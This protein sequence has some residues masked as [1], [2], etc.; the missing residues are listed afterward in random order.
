MNTLKKLIHSPQV[1]RFV[2]PVVLGILF[3]ISRKIAISL[4]HAQPFSVEILNP[5]MFLC[6]TLLCIFSYITL[7]LYPSFWITDR[8]SKKSNRLLLMPCLLIPVFFTLI[9]HIV[10]LNEPLHHISWTKS[11]S[12]YFLSAL[13]SGWGAS[14]WIFSRKTDVRVL[15]T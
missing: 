11:W 13:V 6:V 9:V 5:F 7:I 4:G 8:I 2:S 10:I 15:S 12:A 1:L 3:Y 14:T